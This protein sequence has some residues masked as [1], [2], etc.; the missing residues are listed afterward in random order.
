MGTGDVVPGQHV[1]HVAHREG[2]VSGGAHAPHR[3]QILLAQGEGGSRVSE[4]VIPGDQRYVCEPSD[5]AAAGCTIQ[6]RE[7]RAYGLGY[8]DSSLDRLL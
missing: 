3:H 2:T 5:E 1:V 6:L 4:S 7:T 8:N